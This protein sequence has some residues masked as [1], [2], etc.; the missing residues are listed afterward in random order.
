MTSEPIG[1]QISFTDETSQLESFATYHT[2]AVQANHSLAPNTVRDVKS[3]TDF[4]A[5]FKANAQM[6][7]NEVSIKTLADSRRVNGVLVLE[8]PR[9]SSPT[10]S[11]NLEK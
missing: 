11:L 5:Y 10:Q 6:S 3:Y 9:R 8:P 7:A 1:Y 2:S 4:A